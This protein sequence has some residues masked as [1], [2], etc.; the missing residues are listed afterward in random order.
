MRTADSEQKP[1]KFVIL[2]A[3]G[4]IGSELSR[5]LVQAGHDVFLGG[6]NQQQLQTLAKEL[7]APFQTIEGTNPEAIERC[8]QGACGKLGHV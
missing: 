5:R 1:Q 2:G 6:R 4:A 3:T 7:A 8:I